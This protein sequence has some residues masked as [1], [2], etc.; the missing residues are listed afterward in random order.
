M[1]ESK[2]FGALACKDFRLFIFGNSLSLVGTWVQRIG[3]GWLAWEASHSSMWLGILALA[4]LF[5]TV[6]LAPI[7]GVIA[8]RCDRRRIILYCQ[9]VG[10]AMAVLQAG[11]LLSHAS[12]M[13]WLLAVTF[14]SGIASALCQSARLSWIATLVPQRRVASAVAINSLCFNLARFVGP[15][16]AGALLLKLDPA[17]L[18]LFNALSYAAFIAVF[19]LIPVQPHPAESALPL[20]WLSDITGGVR[21]LLSNVPLRAT[22]VILA[23]SAVC[24]RGVPDMAPAIAGELLQRG[25]QGF[26]SLVAA[27]GAGALVGG[28]WFG[29]RGQ[30]KL[31]MTLIRLHVL[32]ASLC[33]LA[34]SLTHN[35]RLAIVLFFAMGFSVVVTGIG[36]QTLIHL[37]VPQTMRGRVLALYGVIYRGGPALNALWLGA[38]A[39]LLGLRMVLGLGALLCFAAYCTAMICATR[40]AR[41]HLPPEQ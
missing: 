26:A 4:D 19:F 13:E 32:S 11:L 2:R 1:R 28:V 38:S 6:L 7:A 39:P 30:T 9:Y 18:F 20:Y 36:A 17:A 8:D 41:H 33:A 3:T 35:F 25:P 16:I 23:A 24:I 31:L 40:L 29:S 10:A 12:S 34:L 14:I 22:L 5:P 21:Y 37:S 27:T 15:A